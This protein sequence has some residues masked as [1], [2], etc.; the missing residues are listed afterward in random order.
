MTREQV[1]VVLR[2]VAPASVR[3]NPANPMLHSEEQI[4]QI[5]DSIREFGWTKPVL[6]DE[7]DELIAGHGAVRAALKLGLPTI[8][9]ITVSGLTTE[10]KHKLLI[11]DNKIARNSSWDP[12]KLRDMIA[13]LAGMGF[14]SIAVMG[15]TLG[16]IDELLGGWKHGL[17]P[18]A[19]MEANANPTT[20]QV[21]IACRHLD[22]VAIAAKVEGFMKGEAFEEVSVRV[23]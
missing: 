13:P 20:G 8:T 15:F 11:A 7:H 19:A 18:V 22:A 17:E 23:A 5:C 12:D 4:R 21:I 3:E 2:H 9:A 10:Q 14:E 16:E 6:V 1:A